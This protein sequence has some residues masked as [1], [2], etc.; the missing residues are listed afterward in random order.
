MKRATFLKTALATVAGSSFLPALAGDAGTSKK[1]LRV[2]HFTDIH[3]KPGIV[4]EA[5]MAQALRHLQKLKPGVSFIINGGDAIMD[6][7]AVDKQKALEQFGLFKTILQRENNLPVYH[8]IGNHD[9]WGWFIKENKPDQDKSF[10]KAMVL[11]EFGMQR[12]YYSFTHGRWH[13]LVLDSTQ[14]NP[15]GG[16]IARLD[17][18]QLDWLRAE[19]KQVPADKHICIIS[20]IPVLS[21]CAGLFF[22]RTEKNGDLRIQRNLMHSDFLHLKKIFLEHPNIRACI[23]GHIHLQ[24]ELEYLGIRYFCN[25]AVSGSWWGGPFQE[26]APAYAVMEFYDDGTVRREMVDYGWKKA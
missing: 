21:I 23:S 11:E 22:N 13:F 14:L 25:G 18:A 3:L 26:F 10:G 17:E 15:E 6:A 4:P 19:L 16:Y 5:G 8:C 20:H 12:P 7:L 1:P 2:A 9:V 24:D